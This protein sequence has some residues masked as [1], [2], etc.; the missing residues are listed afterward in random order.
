MDEPSIE[1]AEAMKGVRTLRELP[2]FRFIMAIQGHQTLGPALQ[3]AW[4]CVEDGRIEWRTI[5]THVVSA[6]EYLAAVA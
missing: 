3:R 1:I 5:P 2:D 4:Q 6:E